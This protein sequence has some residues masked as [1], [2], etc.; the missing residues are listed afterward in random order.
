L[1]NVI[2]QVDDDGRYK[3]GTEKGPFLAEKLAHAHIEANPAAEMA[4]VEQ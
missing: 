3:Q 4:A 2:W 1:L